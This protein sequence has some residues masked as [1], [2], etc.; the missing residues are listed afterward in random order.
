MLILSYLVELS[1]SRDL[2]DVLGVR[3]DASSQDIKKAYRKEALGK[4]PDKLAPF[5]SLEEE[6]KATFFFV[7]IAKAYETLSDPERRRI[8]D[9]SG[10]DGHSSK[11]GAHNGRNGRKS[12]DLFARTYEEAPFDLFGL[13]R[14]GSFKLH[15]KGKQPRSMPPSV[16]NIPVR[17]D[18]LLAGSFKVNI[19]Y[20]RSIRCSK[21]GGTGHSS[22]DPPN[23]Y[24]TRP[25]CPLCEG[26][27]VRLH[28]FEEDSRKEKEERG[29]DG[30]TK[31][32]SS[33]TQGHSNFHDGENHWRPN[34]AGWRGFRQ[35]VNTT[36]KTCDGTGRLSD[37]N[38]TMCGGEGLIKEEVTVEIEIPAGVPDG[39]QIERSGQGDEHQFRKSGDLKLMVRVEDHPRFHRDG[40]DLILNAKCTLVEALLGFDNKKVTTLSGE[41]LV[42]RHDG[43]AFTGF[44]KIFRGYGLPKF[45]RSQNK[46]L[47][48]E[49]DDS[50]DLLLESDTKLGSRAITNGALMVRF[51]VIFPKRLTYEQRKVLSEV[52]GEEDATIFE[53]LL[54]H[55]TSGRYD[56]PV[57]SLEEARY[58]RKC[59]FDDGGLGGSADWCAPVPEYFTWWAAF[60]KVEDDAYLGD[61]VSYANDYE[62][63]VTAGGSGVFDDYYGA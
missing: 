3:R 20:S 30:A 24:A 62:S 61:S 11:P 5:A 9:L 21:C 6:K 31:S 18:Q 27:K 56:L 41:R 22:Y 34:G 25:V 15:F 46:S 16:V 19:T 63:W 52:L 7:E 43:E 59:I 17:L 40:D 44:S 2:Y 4:H 33:N 57:L 58:C 23:D 26:R 37:K 13:F 42:V 60:G 51:T 28:L 55:M 12:T 53:S 10:D 39:F 35:M 1:S 29:S 48:D 50:T 32:D 14:G 45:K 54:R 8:Y 47:D 49:Q 38:C 36:C